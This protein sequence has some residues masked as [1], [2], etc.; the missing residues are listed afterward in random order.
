LGRLLS[1]TS[2]RQLFPAK[3]GGWA[4]DEGWEAQICC[5]QRPADTQAHVAAQERQ[6]GEVGEVL[7]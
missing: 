5:P 2:S 3:R 4:V 7:Q 1:P 6:D